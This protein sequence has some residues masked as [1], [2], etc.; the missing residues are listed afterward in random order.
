MQKQGIFY[1]Y[2]AHE[3]YFKSLVFPPAFSDRAIRVCNRFCRGLNCSMQKLSAI[4]LIFI[5]L[6]STP[7]WRIE[8]HF[9]GGEPVATQLLTEVTA[10]DVAQKEDQQESEG[11]CHNKLFQCKSDQGNCSQWLF[12]FAP[13][14]FSPWANLPAIPNFIFPRQFIEYIQIKAGKDPPWRV[15][16][17]IFLVYRCFR[18]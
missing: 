13:L 4:C 1:P 10:S 7:G 2:G 11:C 16:N 17:A 5:Y 14:W 9:C 3:L 6:V 8:Q 15:K 18:L 12:S